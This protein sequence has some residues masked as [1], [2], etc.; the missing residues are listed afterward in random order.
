MGFHCIKVRYQIEPRDRIYVKGYRFLS[1]AKKHRKDLRN[2]K[3]KNFLIALKKGQ[4]NNII[5]EYQKIANLLDNH[6]NLEQKIG[7]K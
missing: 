2:R 6:L 1:I 7:S 3:K 4:Y 5:M